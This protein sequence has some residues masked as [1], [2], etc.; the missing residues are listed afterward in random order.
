M[1]LLMGLL[2][3]LIVLTYVAA[4]LDSMQYDNDVVIYSDEATTLIERLLL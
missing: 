3:L 2:T 4:K 1:I